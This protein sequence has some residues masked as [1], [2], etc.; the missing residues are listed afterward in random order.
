MSNYLIKPNVWQSLTDVMGTNY[1]SNK[2]YA[3]HVNEVNRG[4]LRI[5]NTSSVPDN[6]MRGREIPQFSVIYLDKEVGNDVYLM[7]SDT[8]INICIFEITN[9]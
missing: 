3:I 7:A 6:E 8:D 1:D 5:E 2:T 4:C 9:S